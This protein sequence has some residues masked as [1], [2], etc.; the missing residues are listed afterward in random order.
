M[1]TVWYLFVLSVSVAL[2]ST[3]VVL[4]FINKTCDQSNTFLQTFGGSLQ[5]CMNE[6]DRRSRCKTIMFRRG[7]GHCS[8]KENVVV[9]SLRDIEPLCM[10]LKKT[11]WLPSYLGPCNQSQCGETEKCVK[12]KENPKIFRC[13]KSECRQPTYIAQTYLTS[14]KKSVGSVNRYKCK[15]GYTGFGAAS[16][17]CKDDAT[18]STT[19]FHCLKNCKKPKTVYNGV[20]SRVENGGRFTFFEGTVL[21]FTCGE[22]FQGNGQVSNSTCKNGAWSPNRLQ[23]CDNGTELWPWWWRCTFYTGLVSSYGE[24]SSICSAK[25]YHRT[26]FDAALAKSMIQR[27]GGNDLQLLT[28]ETKTYLSQR[29]NFTACLESEKVANSSQY[30][31]FT[32]DEMVEFI[33]NQN[34]TDGECRKVNE[35]EPGQPDG[36]T[37]ETCIARSNASS[38]LFYDVMCYNLQDTGVGAVCH[39]DLPVI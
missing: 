15:S 26:S 20:L 4:K 12:S 24:A 29:F 8:L 22:N 31:N 16:I 23:C 35:W 10:Y 19:N 32:Y 21:H 11:D 13:L 30:E 7:M 5:D 1:G 27:Y 34:L 18:W 28:T 6:C 39:K 37:S 3:A 9:S 17:T 14:N 2:V 38:Y 25:N 36:G 33:R